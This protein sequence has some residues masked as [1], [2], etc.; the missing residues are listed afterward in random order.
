M[1]KHE[2]SGFWDIFQKDIA[3]GDLNHV[4]EEHDRISKMPAETKAKF[5][6]FIEKDLEERFDAVASV[7]STSFHNIQY[8][9]GK[10][11]VKLFCFF[12]KDAR[13]NVRV[14]ADQGRILIENIEFV[15]EAKNGNISKRLQTIQKA[16][17]DTNIDYNDNHKFADFFQGVLSNINQIKN[18]R[19]N[20]FQGKNK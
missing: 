4:K 6:D 18:P 15:S 12:S 8:E 9:L 13:E 19:T 2:L 17:K 14:T 1:D 20:P 5:I 3:V 10:P 7:K 11:I 16:F